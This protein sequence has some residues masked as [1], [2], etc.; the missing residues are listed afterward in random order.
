[1]EDNKKFNKQKHKLVPIS[2]AEE[3]P[4]HINLSNKTKRI[5]QIMEKIILFEAKNSITL[6]KMG[7]AK[8][9]L[10]TIILMSS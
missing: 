1:L 4:K 10:I 5:K 7:R 3:Q 8:E 2:N 9:I 6:K